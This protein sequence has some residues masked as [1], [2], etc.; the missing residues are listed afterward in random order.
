M[1]RKL[2]NLGGAIRQDRNDPPDRGPRGARTDWKWKRSAAVVFRTEG[3]EIHL[4]IPRAALGLRE[5]EGPLS[6]DFKWADGIRSPDPADL[7]VSGDVAPDGRFRFRYS[8]D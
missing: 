6:I 3:S 4:A 2:E 8:A 5:G 1:G 7:Y